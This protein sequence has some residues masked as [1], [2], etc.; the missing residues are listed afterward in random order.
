MSPFDH[1]TR[2][3]PDGDDAWS[4]VVHPAWNIGQNPN[5]GYLMALAAAALRQAAPGH[6]DPLS[7]TV[8]YLQPGVSGRPCRVE[9]RLL[10]GGRQL[11]PRRA[12]LLQE[13][14]PRLEV[15]AAF[16]DLS[17]APEPELAPPAPSLPPP[18]D[19]V[20]RSSD[21]Q[22]V[23]LPILYGGRVNP[24]NCCDLA[25]MS[26]SD[27][28]FIGRSA[29]DPAGYIGIIDAVTQRLGETS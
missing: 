14:S 5:G 16:G 13:G 11:C 25:A 12:R 27:G 6:P 20:A 26:D 24:Q 9:G 15:L 28:L 3:V 2:M 17:G 1:D 29:W 22:G 21:A 23:P 8:H 10:R 18:E 19:C 4:G 7:L